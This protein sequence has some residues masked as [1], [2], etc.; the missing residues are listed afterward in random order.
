M[1]KL[2]FRTQ[3]AEEMIRQMEA[4]TTPWQKPWEAGVIRTA[5]FNPAGDRNYRGINAVWLGMQG[6]TDPRWMT[7]RQAK[8]LGAQVRGGEKG[9]QVEYWQWTEKKG[10]L[11]D[12]GQPVLGEDGKQKETEVRLDRPRMFLATVFNAEQIDGLEPFIPPPANFDP[13]K[14]AE[15]V[16]KESGVSIH[17]D[18][19]SAFYRPQDDSVHLPPKSAF[20][21]GYEYYATALHE[22]GHATGHESRLAREFG[23]FGSEKYAVE[24]LRAEMA[25]FALCTELGVGHHPERHAGYVESWVEALKKDP[26][27]IFRAA[28]DA[29]RIRDWIAEPELRPKLEKEAKERAAAQAQDSIGKR[30]ME[31]DKPKHIDAFEAAVAQG[32]LSEDPEA[33]NYLGNFT[34][35]EAEGKGSFRHIKT[36][37]NLRTPPK[38]RIYLDVP[39]AEKDQAKAGGA[40]WDRREKKWYVL[41]GMGHESITKWMPSAEARP[42]PTVSPTEEFAAALKEQG[43]IVK[44]TPDMDGE[45]HRV[46]V[47]GDKKGQKSGSYR[48]FTDGVPNGQIANFKTGSDPVKWVATGAVLNAD[49]RSRLERDAKAKREMRQMERGKLYRKT[50]GKAYGIWS[51][52]ASPDKGHPYLAA[53]GVAAHGLK[54]TPDNKLVMPLVD[55]G[56]FVWN[57]QTITGE[58]EKRFLKEGKK[59]GLMHVVDP[60]KK[61]AEAP[62][63]FIAE[64]YATAASIHESTGLPAV[65]ALD[66]GNLP[67]VAGIIR[68][69]HPEADLVIAADNDIRKD[70]N[71]GVEKAMEAAEKVGAKWV[72]P[73]FTVAEVE[74]GMTDFNDLARSRGNKALAKAIEA[75]IGPQRA[76]DGGRSPTKE[77]SAEAAAMGM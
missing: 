70:R 37:E 39:Y 42:A 71:V 45:W 43:L 62:R 32:H 55:A 3:V 35:V 58:G 53:K 14:M 47:E 48:A 13:V 46:P 40:K 44:G 11:D 75:G 69:K 51:N 56:G 5:P 12:N 68:K 18:Q 22:V 25:A 36:G 77:R 50:A 61:I 27:A 19:N 65:V 10:V 21:E 20:S 76:I 64:G 34:Y 63:I 73:G 1:S 30:A 60:G 66:A 41:E 16:L 67:T 2:N 33:K 59:R 8:A 28:R 24:E 4:G 6:R 38:R 17:H 23:P 49:E 74:A 29:E 57:I 7:F 15:A 54:V 26:N 31:E 9:T 52:A 72:A